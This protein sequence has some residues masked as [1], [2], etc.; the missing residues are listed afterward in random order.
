MYFCRTFYERLSLRTPANLLMII[1]HSKFVHTSDLLHRNIVKAIEKLVKE[2]LN[3]RLRP[4]ISRA[5]SIPAGTRSSRFYHPTYFRSCYILSRYENNQFFCNKKSVNYK[6]L[7]ETSVNPF[8][9]LDS[10]KIQ[11]INT[12]F[13]MHFS[14]EREHFI[15][16]YFQ[17]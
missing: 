13:N 4:C 5:R 1:H 10:L 2:K 8:F 17:H 7:I 14:L 9:F 12:E 15:Q 3:S 16:N 11:Y 6:T